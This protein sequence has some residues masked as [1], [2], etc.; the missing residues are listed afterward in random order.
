VSQNDRPRSGFHF[1]RRFYQTINRFSSA[2][3]KAITPLMITDSY[4]YSITIM[5]VKQVSFDKKKSVILLRCMENSQHGIS[6]R[7]K[8]S[9]RCIRR[10]IRK[11][12]KFH[13]FNTKPGS[14]R[15]RKVTKTQERLIKLPQLRDHTYSF[16]DLVLVL[17][18][19]YRLVVRQSVVSY[20][21]T[22]CICT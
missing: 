12:D 7:L 1:L 5:R 2:L 11:F 20:A 10:T 8:I 19:N 4:K 14:E 3:H 22:I 13:M 6:C 18:S 16:A 9:R 21:V 15:P 17:I